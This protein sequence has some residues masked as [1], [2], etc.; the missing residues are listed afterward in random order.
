M[1]LIACAVEGIPVG[2]ALACA[3][4]LGQAFGI[5]KAKA[6]QTVGSSS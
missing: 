2:L 1:P 4:R 5:A 6:N 3:R